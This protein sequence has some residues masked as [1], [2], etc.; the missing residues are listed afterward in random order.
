MGKKKKKRKYIPPGGDILTCSHCG[1]SEYRDS[2][3]GWY[4]LLTNHRFNY[5]CRL[6]CLKKWIKKNERVPTMPPLVES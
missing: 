1:K 5:L 4:L 3:R 6:K 2:T